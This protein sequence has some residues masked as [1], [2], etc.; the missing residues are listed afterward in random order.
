MIS[1][2]NKI[3][4]GNQEISQVYVGDNLVF[5]GE[6]AWTPYSLG[7][8]LALWLDATDTDTITLNGS[9]VS[10]WGDKSNNNRHAAQST[11]TKQPVY[12][13]NVINGKACVVGDDTDDV[14]F[15][16]LPLSRTLDYTV[17]MVLSLLQAADALFDFY[18]AATPNTS[19]VTS[20]SSGVARA[21][22]SLAY[23]L[24]R[25]HPRATPLIL[26]ATHQNSAPAGQR[27]DQFV[28]GVRRGV[29]PTDVNAPAFADGI[30]TEYAILDDVTGGNAWGG[31]IGEYIIAT[32]LSESD[33]QKLEGYLA[34]KWGLTANLP[35]DHPYK[36]VAP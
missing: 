28:N 29:F 8:S 10:Q 25:H 7:S 17:V 22:G 24:Q 18:D 31:G 30:F 34:H 33:R 16:P 26:A 13:P 3:Y 2:T 35:S 23:H 19:R 15:G 21:V 9:N 12:A 11:A 5:G 6:T 1:N 4:F 14:L 20:S 27:F 32:G 36:T